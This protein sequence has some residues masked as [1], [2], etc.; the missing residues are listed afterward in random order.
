[1]KILNKVETWDSKVNFVDENNVVL[2]YDTHQDC[3]EVAGWFLSDSILKEDDG[4]TDTIDKE[5]DLPN[6]VFD[7]SFHQYVKHYDLDDGKMVVFRLINGEQEK[8]L[9]LY[10]SHNGYYAHGFEFVHDGKTILEAD[11]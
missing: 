7:T 2:G 11:L 10:N 3:C 4:Y 1:M 5:I 8:F 6:W 9:H